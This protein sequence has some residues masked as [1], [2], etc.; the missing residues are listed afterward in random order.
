MSSVTASV[1]GAATAVSNVFSAECGISEEQRLYCTPCEC[2]PY[3]LGPIHRRF[4]QGLRPGLICSGPTALLQGGVPLHISPKDLLSRLDA[5]TEAIT[6]T[7]REA[8]EIESPSDDK[9]ALD[10]MAQFAAGWFAN[11]GGRVTML[12]QAITGVY[13]QVTFGCRS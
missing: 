9:A 8:S 6:A 3:G 12:P 11:L 10:R 5:S 13:L 7:I 4:P 1:A 2:R